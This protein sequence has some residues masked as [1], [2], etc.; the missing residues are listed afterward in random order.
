MI[1]V[2]NFAVTNA[3]FLKE[4]IQGFDIYAVIHHEQL[5]LDATTSYRV[6]PCGNKYFRAVTADL[7]LSSSDAILDIDGLMFLCS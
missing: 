6:Y 5:G 2:A 7:R 4:L 3:R 1:K